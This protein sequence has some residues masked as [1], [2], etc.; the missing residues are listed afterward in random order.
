[1]IS[2][3]QNRRSFL[4]NASLAGAGVAAL[5]MATFGQ[6]LVDANERTSKM[7]APSDIRITAVKVAYSGGGMF[8]KLE[9]NQTLVS[10]GEPLDASVGTYYLLKRMAGQPVGQNPFKINRI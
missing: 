3:K 5:P 9:S 2:N 8:V 7:S 1:M 6:G 4:K 10:W